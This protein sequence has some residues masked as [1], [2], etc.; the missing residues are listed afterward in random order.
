MLIQEIPMYFIVQRIL[1]YYN[2]MRIPNWR[3][4]LGI[5]S[6]GF[7][8]GLKISSSLTICEI[9]LRFLMSN[10]LYLAFAFSINNC[11]DVECDKQHK[12]KLKRN[13]I[14]AGLI[15]FKEGV[16]VSLCFASIGLVFTYLCFSWISF[17]IY[18]ILI[19]LSAAYSCPPLRLKSVPIFDL[20]SHGLFFG[21]L[22]FFY[23]TSVTGGSLYNAITVNISIFIYSV[24]LEL[25]NHI[26]DFEADLTSGLKTTVCW[27]GFTKAKRLLKI[28]LVLHLLLLSTILYFINF[29]FVSVVSVFAVASFLM[30]RRRFNH[31]LR[32]LDLFSSIV[33]AFAVLSH[34]IRLYVP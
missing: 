26:E 34:L 23:G 14:V 15:G 21:S 7:A 31:Y 11:F 3:A 5:A 18:S 27:V 19:L 9:F 13:P 24:T 6:L 2:N 22:L 30:L 1:L 4:Y 12:G 17:F 29:Q 33:Y 8:C 28:L 32:M 25:R 20:F 16:I 10:A